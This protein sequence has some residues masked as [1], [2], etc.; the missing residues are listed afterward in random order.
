MNAAIVPFRLL[1]INDSQQEAQRLTS[2][3]QNAGKPCRAQH[4]D[5]EEAFNKIIEEQSWDL[6]IAHSDSNSLTPAAAI[7]A[8]RKYNHDLP[9]IILAEDDGDRSVV[10]GMKLGA[11]DVVKLD[12][13]QHLL[14]VVNRELENRQQRKNTRAAERKVK[15][16]EQRNHQL[17]DSSKDG[18]AFMQDGM[19]I[20]AN[21]SFAEMCGYG[22]R[23]DIE[24][25][26][27]MDMISADNQERVKSSLKNFSLQ[28][29][30]APEGRLSFQIKTSSGEMKKIDAELQLSKYEEE[31]CIQFTLPAN[32]TGNEALE[33]E[34]ASIKHTDSLTGLYNKT[35]LNQKLSQLVNSAAD[36]EVA[37][38]FFYIDID[39]FE[40]KV[41]SRVGI[42]GADEVLKVVSDILK[43][44]SQPDDV[45]ARLS[46]HVFAIITNE[47]HL[48]KLLNTGNVLCESIREHFFEV[49]SNTLRLTASVGIAMINETSIDA[50]S[51]IK[52]ASQAIDNLRHKQDSEAGDGANLFQ[53]I[54]DDHT[55]LV[56]SLQ[57]ALNNNDFKLL[58]QPIISLRGDETERYEVL[59]RMLD[60]NGEEISPNNFLQTAESMKIIT[61][62]DRWVILESIKHLS[63]HNKKNG[64]AQL[65]VNISHNTLCDE[66]VIPWL[67]VAFKAAKV[68]P[69]CI[70][71]QAKETEII[72]HLTS[73]KKFIEE[74]ASM[75]IGF[76]VNQFGCALDPFS[77]LEHIEVEHI[78]I[79]GSFS[80]DIQ[81]NPDNTEA[82][83]QLLKELHS[84]SKV[85]IIPLVEN[86]SILSKLWKMGVHCIQGYYLQP[87]SMA[88]NYEFGVESAG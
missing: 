38:A 13:D 21:D 39:Q 18:I 45:L 41:E 66:T 40:E 29:E 78:K 24:Y 2:M 35:H 57:K 44:H 80:V 84:R 34:I 19:Y 37:H 4:I 85:T 42:D 23:G 14:L 51:V 25:M 22:N 77:L 47:V 12:D 74:A 72:E 33:A 58:F 9:L 83:E 49:K 75:G 43:S 76:C 46:D 73:S 7:R 82:I 8:V 16:M 28:N 10:D 53:T 50:Q 48:E 55:V 32:F 52:Q 5:S 87:P 17:L 88:M 59:L 60:E 27:L 3:F 30:S 86:A 67:K 20:Y 6:A 61:K 65:I 62:I 56:S 68:D 36:D 69:K 70:I 15:E 54:E 79:D 64:H 63:N 81:E 26:P 11:C 31:S 71:F 1:I